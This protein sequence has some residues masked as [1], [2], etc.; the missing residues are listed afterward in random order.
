[1]DMTDLAGRIATLLDLE[2]E[3]VDVFPSENGDADWGFPVAVNLAR[4]PD[5]YALCDLEAS[6][7]ARQAEF[8]AEQLRESIPT[9]GAGR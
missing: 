7:L 8:C 2:P 6:T 3:D 1:M 4:Y 9:G 5:A